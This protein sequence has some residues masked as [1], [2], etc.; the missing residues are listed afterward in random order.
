[1]TLKYKIKETVKREFDQE[2]KAESPQNWLQNSFF[3]ECVK[4]GKEVEV[5]TVNGKKITGVI[6][7]YDNYSFFIETKDGEFLIYKHGV[8]YLKSGR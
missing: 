6:S 3:E 2:R 1:M 5:F 4:S 7:A 8:V